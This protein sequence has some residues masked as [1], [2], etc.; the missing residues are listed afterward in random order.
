MADYSRMTGPTKFSFF[1]PVLKSIIIAN[2]AVF[3]LQHFILGALN[4]SGIPLGKLFMQYFALMPL[5]QTDMLGYPTESYFYFWQ[6]ITYQFMHGGFFHLFFNL[7]AL[8]MFGS[9][10]EHRWGSSKF[11][12]YY[13]LAGVGAA[14]V[15]LFISPLLGQA[16]PTIGA[17]GSVYGILLAFGMTFPDRPIFMFPI[18]IPIP[19]KFFVV[20]YAGI[21]LV[22]GLTGNDGIAHFA[23]L[24]GAATGLLLI[25]FGDKIGLFKFVNKIFRIKSKPSFPNIDNSGYEFRSN[26][27]TQPNR[28]IKVHWT[29]PSDSVAKE[30]AEYKVRPIVVNGE[31]VNQQRIDEILDKI[32]EVG[33]HKLTEKE[34]SILNEL[35]KRL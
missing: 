30:T 5:S 14:L 16:A 17:S 3:L 28:N 4:M 12:T 23:H 2:V 19:A 33:Y 7:F 13:L 25:L 10:L 8:W 31:I 26:E 27:R 20:L 6:V 18:F 34:K 29:S 9:E 32:S 35:S 1:P 15:Q 11:L 21:E 24:G 22:S